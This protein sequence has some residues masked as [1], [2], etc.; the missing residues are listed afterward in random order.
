[1]ASTEPATQA[2]DRGAGVTAPSL[3]VLGGGEHARVVVD[4]ARS[5]TGSWDIE[6]FVAPDAGTWPDVP[7]LGDDDDLAKRIRTT[8]SAE[9]PWLVIGFGGGDTAA[10]LTTRVASA[11]GLDAEDHWATIVHATA[12]VAPTA[13]LEPG[14]VVLANAV[15]NSGAAVGRHCIVNSGAVIEHDVVLG[16]G[17]HVAPGAVIGGGTRVGEGTFI[18]LGAR[19]RDH[20]EIGDGV[21]VGMGSVVVASVPAGAQVIGVAARTT[22]AEPGPG[23]P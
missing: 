6:G 3:V 21:V 4:A 22:L 17:S 23:R 1:M 18:G 11:A 9:R 14:V 8:R 2:P 15:V 16:A 12:W 20:I 7:W 19:I 5:V 10:G 13:T